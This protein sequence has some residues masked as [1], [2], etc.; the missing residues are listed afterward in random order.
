METNPFNIST[1]CVKT[2]TGIEILKPMDILY[3]RIED[4]KVMFKLSSSETVIAKHSLKELEPKL[5]LYFF[6]RCH[7]NCLVNLQYIRRYIH[8]TGEI[9]MID[10]TKIT[11]AK[12]RKVD[13]YKVISEDKN[14][15]LI[16]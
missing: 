10:G 8:K 1:I 6:Y 15:G 14:Y 5:S 7:A 13:F 4:D 11:V 2:S 9:T 3:C 16:G 12:E